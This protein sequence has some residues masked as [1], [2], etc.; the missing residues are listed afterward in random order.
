M[1][2]LEIPNQEQVWNNIAPEWHRHKEKPLKNVKEF[3]KNSQGKILD[4]GSGSGRHLIKFNNKKREYYLVDFSFE[5]IKLAEQKSKKLGINAKFKVADLTN[6]P[7]ENNFFDFSIC[8]SAIHCIPKEK[9]RKKAISEMYRVLKPS[10]KAYIGV[11]NIKSKRFRNKRPERL[12]GWTNKGK[13]YYHLYTKDEIEKELK[14]IG[15]KILEDKSS[16]MMINFV[17]EK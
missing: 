8:V 10:G 14:E 16:E 2:K 13:R 1:K 17:V 7:Y 12:I 11:W 3:L 9:N 15:F 6:L 4:F 5:M